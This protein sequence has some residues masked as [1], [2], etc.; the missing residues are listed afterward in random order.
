MLRKFIQKTAARVADAL[1]DETRGYAAA[2]IHRLTSDW[3]T[4][5]LSA[6]E[7]I[8]PDLRSL[9][10]SCRKLLR[11]DDYFKNY[12]RK[13]K[14]NVVGHKGMAMKVESYLEPSTVEAEAHGNSKLKKDRKLAKVVEQGWFVWCKMQYASASRKLSFVDLQRLC[15][16]SVAVDGEAIFRYIYGT[17]VFGFTL[18]QID[19]DWLDENY[20][21]ELPNGNRVVMSV[22]MD[23]YDAPV[24]YHFT[25]PRHTYY[26]VMRDFGISP[27]GKRIRVPAE[28]ILH[29]F[30][31][32]RPGQTRGVPFAHT[33]IGRVRDLDRYENAE[34]TNATVSASKMGFIAPGPDAP[35]PMVQ[36]LNDGKQKEVPI[37]DQVSPG[38]IQKLPKG[39]TFQSFDPKTPTSVFAV[40]CKQILRGIA[41]GLGIGYNLLTG[42]LEGV[43]YSSLRSASLDERD[44]WKALQQWMIEH[45]YEPIYTEWL[46]VAVGS[47]FVQ[48]PQSVIE[49]VS[50]PCFK[51]RGW[52]WVDPKKEADANAVELGNGTATYSEILAEKGLE[53]EETMERHKYERDYITS[54]GLPF[55]QVMQANE[56]NGKQPGKSGGGKSDTSS[57][58]GDSNSQ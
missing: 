29:C 3:M 43:N 35:D 15:I 42:D 36:A 23:Q 49:Q 37:L 51:A 46:K 10:A 13:L 21:E 39:W 47:P 5:L 7:E 24:A 44:E 34:L 18:Q 2:R 56:A 4:T 53:F 57:G 52:G 30:I 55:A 33:V 19:P 6:D 38:M 45:F 14:N 41:A 58:A 48:I 8:W 12:I 22:E 50:N 1:S 32:L 20:S 9:R 28:E 27:R 11:D 40:F 16:E 17:N 25:P 26:G 54:L 31:S